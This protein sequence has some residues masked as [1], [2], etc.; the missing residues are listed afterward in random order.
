M[1]ELFQVTGYKR[2]GSHLK[3]IILE[4]KW[5]MPL[6]PAFGRQR[7]LDLCEFQASLVYIV[8]SRPDRATQ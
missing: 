8:G 6:I 3:I 4:R 7:Q 1:V 2:I 5:H